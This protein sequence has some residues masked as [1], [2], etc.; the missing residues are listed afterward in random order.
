M[1]L[2]RCL[3]NLKHDINNGGLEDDTFAMI[4]YVTMANEAHRIIK[5]DTSHQQ[6]LDNAKEYLALCSSSESAS[7][8][9]VAE[10]N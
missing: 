4:C 10:V 1:D 5:E 9:C 8:R 2:R 6:M 7:L 3:E